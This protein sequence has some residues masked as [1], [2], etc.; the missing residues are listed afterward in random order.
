M[1]DIFLQ[2]YQPVAIESDS[3]IKLGKK[4]VYYDSPSSFGSSNVSSTVE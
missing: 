4:K 2:G 3:D 1:S